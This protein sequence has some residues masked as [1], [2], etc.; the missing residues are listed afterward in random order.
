MLAV[1]AAG[2]ALTTGYT[3][4]HADR[5]VLLEASGRPDLGR[6]LP[7]TIRRRRPRLLVW[8]AAGRPLG[9]QLSESVLVED[10]HA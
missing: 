5:R 1:A 3:Y 8:F 4:C 9:Q 6:S 7:R 10:G 2:C